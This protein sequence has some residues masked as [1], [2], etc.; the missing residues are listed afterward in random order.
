LAVEVPRPFLTEV[1]NVRNRQENSMGEGGEGREFWVSIRVTNPT[2]R[3]TAGKIWKINLRSYAAA[4]R[5]NWALGQVGED[6]KKGKKGE[7]IETES[8]RKCHLIE[9]SQGINGDTKSHMIDTGR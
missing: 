4:L 6:E 3:C 9:A 5:K 1:R 2:N 7:K 8:R